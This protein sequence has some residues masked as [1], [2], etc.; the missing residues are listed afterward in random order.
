MRSTDSVSL[1]VCTRPHITRFVSAIYGPAPHT[2]HCV[3]LQVVDFR[4]RLAQGAPCGCP[5]ATA[6]QAGHDDPLRASPWVT[7]RRG[8]HGVASVQLCGGDGVRSCG[9]GVG[10]PM[11]RPV[12]WALWNSTLK[13]LGCAAAAR[14]D[15]TQLSRLRSPGLRS[16]VS[17]ET[18]D[19]PPAPRTAVK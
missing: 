6:P 10:A 15:Y 18:R 3:Q 8:V 17:Y 13:S 1:S 16:Q 2:G 12:A 11:W 19:A 5:H 4:T 14:G 7:W 9:P